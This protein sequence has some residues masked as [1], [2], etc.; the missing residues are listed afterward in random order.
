MYKIVLIIMCSFSLCAHSLE[1]KDSSGEV[2]EN[3]TLKTLSGSLG[4]YSFYSTFIYSA[5][6]LEYPTSA[7]RPSIKKEKASPNLTSLSGAMGLKYRLTKSDNFSFQ[8][9]LYSTTP[10]NSSISTNDVNMQRDFD[11]NHQKVTTDDP[12]LSYFKTYYL[13][14]IQNISF[15]KY[16]YVTRDSYRDYGGRAIFQFSHAAAYRI[17]KASYIAGSFT[18][19]SYAYDK[20][21]IDYMGRSISIRSSQPEHKYR[22][23]I[24][25]EVYLSRKVSTRFITDIFSYTR[26]RDN[27]DANWDGRQQTLALS[28]FFNRDISI[29]PNIRFISEDLR[30]ERSN[31]GLTLNVNI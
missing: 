20:S 10:F 13:M 30:P 5:G 8:L 25:F 26:L 27:N 31:F 21:S 12:V 7:Q 11:E 28:Y 6:S 1:K 19:E 16:Q 15:F 3:P 2:V 22:A 18:Y 17:N 29:A 4:V 23:N 24:S 14:N 9:G